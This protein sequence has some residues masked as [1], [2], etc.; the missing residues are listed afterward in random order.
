MLTKIDSEWIIII[1]YASGLS[2]NIWQFFLKKE[3]F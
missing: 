2:V 3:G 1:C